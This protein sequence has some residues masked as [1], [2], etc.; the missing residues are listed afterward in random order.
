MVVLAALGRCGAIH[1]VCWVLQPPRAWRGTPD[2]Q[3]FTFTITLSFIKMSVLWNCSHLNSSWNKQRLVL[4]FMPLPG[5]A[6]ALVSFGGRGWSLLEAH[7]QVWFVG[8][9]K[10][11]GQAHMLKHR[12]TMGCSLEE[13]SGF[14]TLGVFLSPRPSWYTHYLRHSW[15]LLLWFSGLQSMQGFSRFTAFPPSHHHVP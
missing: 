15:T 8:L 14:S 6:V 1:M 11:N 7:K 4:G 2:R 9:Q 12:Q 10:I 13:N 5:P 3:P